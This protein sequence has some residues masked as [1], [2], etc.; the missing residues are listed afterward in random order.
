MGAAKLEADGEQG[1]AP[2]SA[3]RR[4]VLPYEPLAM[5]F[6]EL[7]PEEQ[8]RRSRGFLEIMARR[9]SCRFFSDRSVP[10]ELIVN[11]VRAAGTAPSGA[12]Q[13]PWTFVV[14]TDPAVKAAIRAAAEE[15]ERD[16]YAK[17]PDE[18]RRALLPLGTDAVKHHLTDAP[19]L[20]VVFARVYGLQTD[21]ETGEVETVKHYY[22]RESVGIA[23]GLLLGSL[24]H[25]GLATLPHTPSPMGFLGEVLGR[26]ANERACLL[27]P[28]GFPA[29][30]ATV[31]KH[32]L[33]KKSLDEILVWR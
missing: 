27:I 32:A 13:Q 12:N 17:A 15:H 26:P 5:Y 1:G 19:Y 23:C 30:Q 4:S 33:A 22:V 14:V 6:E 20:V 3:T 25:A 11:A 31:P 18:W 7:A 21:H 16:F 8:L 9:R 10:E 29:E 24:A 2:G 28:V